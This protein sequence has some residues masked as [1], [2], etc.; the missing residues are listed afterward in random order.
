MGQASDKGMRAGE[1]GARRGRQE[2]IPREG[3]GQEESRTYCEGA[4]QWP[5]WWEQEH[6]LEWRREVLSQ[7]NSCSLPLP[8][9]PSDEPTAGR[10]TSPQLP[11]PSSLMALMMDCPLQLQPLKL[12]HPG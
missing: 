5:N 1:R 9:V 10:R 12:S 8:G 11:P 3:Q 2:A 6:D 7:E 4:R